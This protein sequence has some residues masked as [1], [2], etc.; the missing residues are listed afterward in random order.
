MQDHYSVLSVP[1]T[2]S[3]EE[4]KRAYR[5]LAS[6]HHPDRGGNTKQFQ[7]IQSAYN[8]LGD[9]QRRQEY[10]SGGSNTF[11][12]DFGTH[13]F[14][15][16]NIFDVFRNQSFAQ[17]QARR[18]H[19]RM[20]LW[21]SLYDIAVGG[22]RT[23]TVSTNQEI[24]A[25][26]ITIP[27][28]IDDGANVQYAGLGPNGLDLMI[29]FRIRPDSRWERQGL[30][31]VTERKILIWDLILGGSL[32]LS[33]IYNNSLV[34]QIPAGCQP[35]TLLR[36]RGCGLKNQQGQQG[37]A[38]VKVSVNIPHRVAPEITEAI[39]QHRDQ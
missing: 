9:A 32:E 11:R 10:D 22:N 13:R 28:G 23:V 37:D 17:T 21:V 25:I 16:N 4:I 15:F 1:R 8:V 7:E 33:D 20:T 35:G 19:V 38:F 31:L 12:F 39:R 27:Q 29:Q 5:R 30:N 3:A 6:Q 2:A 26:D 18:N 36:L 14:D 24:S 34:T